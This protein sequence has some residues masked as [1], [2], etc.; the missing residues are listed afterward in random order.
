MNP[1]LG[2]G[3][4]DV[5]IAPVDLPT[6]IVPRANFVAIGQQIQQG[7]DEARAA[8]KAAP[9]WLDWVG[10]LVG[11]ILGTILGW[12]ARIFAAIIAVWFQI[13]HNAE[14]GTDAISAAAVSGLFGV[15]QPSS[16]FTSAEQADSRAGVRNSIAQTIIS[17]LFPGATG[18]AGGSIQPGHAGADNF[19]QIAMR[20]AIE[21]WLQGWVFEV[22]SAGQVETFGE[23]KDIVERSLGMGR[24]MRR[25]LAAPL[26]ILL[27][28]PFTWELNQRYHPT[29]LQAGELVREYLRGK[30]DRGA[31]Q[32]A[33]DYHG[34]TSDKVD[35]LINLTRAHMS[36]G[37]LLQ[38]EL[39]SSRTQADTIAALQAQGWDSDTA[40]LVRFVELQARLDA[41]NLKIV[42]EL[43][44]AVADR[45]ADAAALDEF[46]RE[47]GLPDLEQAL[48]RTLTNNRAAHNRTFLSIAEGQQMVEKGIWTLDKFRSL[49]L[50]HGYALGDET[51]LELLLLGKVKDMGDAQ[52]KRDAIAKA[53]ADA[54][55]AKQKAAQAKAA[56]AAAAAQAKGVS[57]AAF[58]ALIADGLKTVD[59]YRVFL[60]GKSIAPDNIDALVTVEQ[61]KLDKAKAA[62]GVAGSATAAAKAKGLSVAQLESAVK[63]G[64]I[65]LDEYQTRLE[66][67]GVSQADALTLREVLSDQ[68]DAA[69]TKASALAQTKATAAVKHVD[70]TQEQKAVRIGL[71]TIDDYSA[72]LAARA[73][74]PE[75]ATLL[76]GELQ[77]QLNADQAAKKLKA[78]NSPTGSAKGLTLAETEKAVRAGVKTIDDYKAALAAQGYDADAQAALVSLLQLQLQQDADTLAAQGRA[79]GLLGQRGVSLTDLARAVKLGV[80]PLSVYTDA[81]GRSGVSSDDAQVLTLTLAA[82]T[83][84]TKQTVG[85]QPA[86]SKL[87]TAAGFS[88]ATLEKDVLAG[89]ITID[90]FTG[91]L[92]G[93]GVAA[94]DVA[95]LAQL[96]S[97][98]LANQA[99]ITGLVNDATARAAAKHLN[100]AQETAAVKAGVKTTDEFAAFVASLGYDAADVATLQ[101]TLL[102]QLGTAAAKKTA[103]AGKQKQPAPTP[104][105]TP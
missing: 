24:L 65:G 33:M 73:F 18:G 95:N 70:L 7:M 92:S 60:A 47:A 90:Q 101:A 12:L 27:E 54:A 80:V 63:T 51:D 2:E 66:A 35:A 98:E 52:A 43:A 25:V 96:A 97:D 42:D 4:P 56:N 103:A 22:G 57:L 78:A 16:A 10:G 104:Q 26:K 100:L 20:I 93:A 77:Q 76:V 39:H 46:M 23:L 32:S 34:Y 13:W 53:K 89:K 75:D 69:K 30:L 55:A 8:V 9:G 41:W 99:H 102:A 48:I 3:G 31:L 44:T 91:T 83:K 5:P 11:L 81:L 85:A 58:Q 6:P 28:D 49:A 88:L 74:A 82:Q 15:A 61:G 87:L 36:P 17:G 64:V 38:L 68:L 84:Q 59:D 86:V 45:K 14:E 50:Q 19:V 71:A 67:A 94:A 29:L 40:P 37:Q 72:F 21:G 105:T 79:S 1:F 62:Q